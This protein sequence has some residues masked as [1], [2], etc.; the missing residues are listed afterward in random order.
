[1][2]STPSPH[3]NGVPGWSPAAGGTVRVRSL[4]VASLRNWTGLRL[5]SV[6]LPSCPLF[7]LPWRLPEFPGLQAQGRG[8]SGSAGWGGP[9][10]REGASTQVRKDCTPLFTG[11]ADWRNSEG[12]GAA[13]RTWLK[14]K[15][16]PRRRGENLQ[17]RP[18]PQG[19]AR[20]LLSLSWSRQ[21]PHR[22]QPQTKSHSDRDEVRRTGSL[23]GPPDPR[24]PADQLSF[25]LVA[26][27]SLQRSQCPQ[28][29]DV[30][31]FPT[32]PQLP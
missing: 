30:P 18:R 2:S 25:V 19:A 29:D 11:T 4:W 10:Q 27:H 26:L 20:A 12:G 31:R 24:A 5:V 15:A 28:P 16:R 3:E 8:L 14:E 21:Q 22:T 13:V 32:A 6:L 9:Q 7:V 23:D 1:M 17:S